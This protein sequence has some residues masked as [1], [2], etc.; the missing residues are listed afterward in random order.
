MVAGSYTVKY[1]NMTTNFELEHI[2]AR[3]AADEGECSLSVPSLPETVIGWG[4]Q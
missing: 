1:E 4:G 3:L 2:A